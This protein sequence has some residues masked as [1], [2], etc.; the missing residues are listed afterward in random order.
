MIATKDWLDEAAIAE[1]R[2]RQAAAGTRAERRILLH[3]GPHKT[4]SAFMQRMAEFNIPRLPPGIEVIERVNPDLL[5]LREITKSLRSAEEA[6]RRAPEIAEAAARVERWTR[7]A[8][9]SLVSHEALLGATPG[10]HRIRGLY[11]FIETILPAMLEGLSGA[12]ASV[13]IALYARDFTAWM[14]SNDAYRRKKEH[15]LVR[16]LLRRPFSPARYAARHG[17]PA[18]WDD[19][20]RR[21]RA[22]AGGRSVHVLSF[23]AESRAGLLG[24]GLWRLMGLS[25][26]EIDG[27]ERIAPQNVTNPAALPGQTAQA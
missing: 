25:E 11:P 27:L 10:R 17:M 21:I 20:H 1:R 18:G 12:G 13:G 23:E 4:G 8:G 7:N 22:A 24:A 14:R 6:R 9:A 5:A 2:A 16:T 26:A 3:L 19:L 15:I